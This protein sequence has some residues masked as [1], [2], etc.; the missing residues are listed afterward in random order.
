MAKM[1]QAIAYLVQGCTL[2]RWRPPTAK[3]IMLNLC[4]WRKQVLL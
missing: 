2:C 1:E 3:Q 4:I